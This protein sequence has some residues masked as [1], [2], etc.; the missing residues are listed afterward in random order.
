MPSGFIVIPTYN[1]RENIGPLVEA[2]FGARPGLCVIIVDD[3]SPDGTGAAADELARRWPALRVIHRAGKGG[4][5]SACLAGFA[6]ALADADCGF[7][8]EMDADFSHDPKEL[9]ETIAALERADVVIR[10]RYHPE[11]RIV[12][13]GLARRIFSRLANMVARNLLRLPLSDLTN[14]YRAYS[15]RAAQAIEPDKITA[16]GYIVLSEIAHQLHRKGF[17]FAELPTV[18]VNR[19]RGQSNLTWRE[20]MGASRGILTLYV[21]SRQRVP[22]GQRQS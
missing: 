8:M 22:S 10:S 20:I 7:V 18:F 3:G 4:R 1:E 21:R 5:G 19:K 13:W 12:N 16:S 6:A 14:G 2:I 17:R 9:N 15:R 11:S